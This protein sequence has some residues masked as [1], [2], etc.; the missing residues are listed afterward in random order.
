MQD[1]ND[2]SIDQF[3]KVIEDRL[4]AVKDCLHRCASSLKGQQALL[5][6]ALKETESAL[7]TPPSGGD[8]LTLHM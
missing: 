3:W 1:V 2:T 4:W 7:N 8:N 6:S 5:Q